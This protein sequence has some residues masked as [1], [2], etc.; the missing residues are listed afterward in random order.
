MST[1]LTGT[2]RTERPSVKHRER[3][4]RATVPEGQLLQVYSP[5]GEALGTAVL[6]AAGTWVDFFAGPYHYNRAYARLAEL[7]RFN[8][9][10]RIGGP[11]HG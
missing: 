5:G 11:Q 4:S 10:Q 3:K 7:V 9:S 1:T 8:K 6:T 2:Q